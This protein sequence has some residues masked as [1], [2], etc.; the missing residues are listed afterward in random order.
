MATVTNLDAVHKALFQRVKPALP[1]ARALENVEFVPP[2]TAPYTEEDFV[3]AT[4]VLWTF[5][6]ENGR[7]LEDGIYVIRYYGERNTGTAA[8]NAATQAILAR[9]P[10]GLALTATDGTMVR[11]G[12]YDGPRPR[13][14][15]RG[16]NKRLDNGRPVAVITIP[17]WLDQPHNL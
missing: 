4:S 12:T 15:Y 13:A 5:P 10:V 14:P 11:I 9:V 2:A 1:A 17:W 6:A 3:P 8:M 7:R 16:A